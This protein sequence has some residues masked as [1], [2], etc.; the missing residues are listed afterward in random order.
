MT[1]A[2]LS[3]KLGFRQLLMITSRDIEVN[4]EEEND[5]TVLLAWNA[6]QLSQKAE[7]KLEDE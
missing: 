5:L 4:T 6:L 1:D 2:R 7:S 3:K